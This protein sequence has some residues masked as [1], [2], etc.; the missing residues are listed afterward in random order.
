MVES[1]ALMR[2]AAGGAV[3]I[4]GECVICMSG[5]PTHG[6]VPC[7]HAVVCGGCAKDAKAASTCYVC[8]A[9][10]TRL[11]KMDRM[12]ATHGNDRQGASE[13]DDDASSAYESE[14]GESYACSCDSECY[15][16]CECGCHNECDS[17]TDASTCG[18]DD[19]CY[20]PHC[21][22]YC[23]GATDSDATD[24]DSGDEDDE[25]SDEYDENAC[26][27]CYSDDSD[28][29]CSCHDCSGSQYDSDDEYA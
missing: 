19:P 3:R 2:A 29:G 26:S 15:S 24:G 10:V 13:S 12:P 25:A 20:V 22:C 1:A 7:G 27:C 4:D 18:C 23:H 6:F 11:V 28:C 21:E 17:V 5:R 9:K 8:R 14:E 16:G